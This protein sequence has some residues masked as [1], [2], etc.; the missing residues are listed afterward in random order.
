MTLSCFLL[1]ASM[2]KLTDT[3][4]KLLRHSVVIWV[5][6]ESGAPGAMISPL[7]ADEEATLSD[8]MY[9][10]VAARAGLPK[11]DK[12]QIDQLL[13]E[14]P[15][16]FAQLIAHG[17]LAPGTYKYDNPLA[18]IPGSAQMMPEELA[19][20]AKDKVVTFQLTERHLKLLHNARWEAMM[21]NPKRP[22]G[23]MTSFEHEMATILGEP[24]DEKALWKLHTEMLP[25]LQVFLQNATLDQ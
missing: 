3:H 21:M 11:V 6:V 14:M 5:P 2:F 18:S 19:S 4:L 15:E 22:Y 23:D 10:D 8:A 24:F 9:A 12:Q 25:A 17:K 13:A 20:L 1:A 16:V 7:L